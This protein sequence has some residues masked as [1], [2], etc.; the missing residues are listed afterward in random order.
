MFEKRI[1]TAHKKINASIYE[2]QNIRIF[3]CNCFMVNLIDLYV[4]TE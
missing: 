4:V 1:F 2:A 3:V